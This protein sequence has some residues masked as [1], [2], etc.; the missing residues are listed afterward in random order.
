MFSVLIHM[1]KIKLMS[2]Q[3]YLIMIFIYFL[4]KTNLNEFIR[5]G[6]RD[7]FTE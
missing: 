6:V 3:I 1:P 2:A 7:I 5:T 4:R